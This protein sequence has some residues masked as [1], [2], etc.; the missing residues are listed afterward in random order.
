MVGIE[1]REEEMMTIYLLIYVKKR[2]GGRHLELDVLLY[3]LRTETGMKRLFEWTGMACTKL[4]HVTRAG[5]HF[6]F[7]KHLQ[8]YIIS[9][10]QMSLF[11]L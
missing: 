4:S 10:L 1:K 2:R 9:N 6:P 8:S 5:K 11:G 7:G 3:P